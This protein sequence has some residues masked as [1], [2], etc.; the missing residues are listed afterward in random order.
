MQM[1]FFW[2][3]D[4]VQLRYSQLLS[5]LSHHLMHASVILESSLSTS[6]IIAH[7]W[8]TGNQIRF[9]F[10]ISFYIS[11]SFSASL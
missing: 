4:P 2:G 8:I 9:Q 7:C 3:Q 11:Y 1:K 6:F 5:S 10:K